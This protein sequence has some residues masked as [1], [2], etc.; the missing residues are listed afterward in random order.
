MTVSPLETR[1]R[2]DMSNIFDEENKLRYWLRVEVALAKT[3]A[4]LG[5][6]PKEA[7][8]EIERAI[9]KVKVE[10]VREIEKKIHHDL[11]AATIALGEQCRK[12]Y[13]A[14]IHVGATSYDIE[15]TATALIFK[16]AISLLRKDMAALTTTL[17]SLAKKHRGTV[18][19][20][21]THGQQAVPTTY[22][23]RF[24]LYYR[25]MK[26]HLERLREAEKRIYAGKMSGAVG[27]M[28]TFRGKGS[29]I[30]RE[31]M[32]E[33]GLKPA[34][35]TNQIVQRDRHAEVLFVISLIGA[36]LEKIAK[37]IRNGQRTEIAEI[38]EPFGRK[39]VGSSAM[40]H[41]RNPHKSERVCSLARILRANVLTAL[42]NIPLEHERDLTNS[43]NERF[44]FSE[45]F[46]TCDYMLSQMNVILKGLVFFPK[47]ISKN[48]NLTRGLIMGERV[49][50]ELC[51]KGMGRQRAYGI[52]RKACVESF[53]RKRDL[54]TVLMEAK[55]V[56]RLLT[57]KE[58]SAIL[59][60]TTYIGEAKKI[61]D[62][63]LRG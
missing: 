3:H 34:L 40:P 36:T 2:T 50:I 12:G 45:S 46:I 1:Y 35:I 37:E 39:Q 44:I 5:D 26:R 14:Y 16:D 61:V 52:V 31:V 8:R 18:C 56:K 10:R 13:G 9:K 42:E 51:R 11:M 38:A 55:E 33:L 23:M 32:R 48:L 27:T 6:I 47:N 53:E 60:P 4:S 57:K 54:G 62:N 30:Q 43:A 24:A 59:D 29:K 19:I 15:D 63:A 25:E 41:K 17:K 21:R 7:P 49:M 28:A 20:G 22:G 58:L